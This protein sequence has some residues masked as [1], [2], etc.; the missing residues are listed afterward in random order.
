MQNLDLLKEVTILLVDDDDAFRVS[1]CNTLE[2][3]GARVLSAS[4]GHDAWS[5]FKTQEVMIVIADIRMGDFSGLSLAKKIRTYNSTIPI[6]IV[7][8]YTQ[9][10]DLIEACRLN[11]I[12][13]LVKPFSF[14]SL[15]N[16]LKR[17]LDRLNLH[18]LI[19]NTITPSIR[20]NPYTKMLVTNEGTEV[21]LSKNEVNIIEFLIAYRGQ[22]IGY[23]ALKDIIGEDVSSAALKNII[24][25]LRKKIGEDVIENIQKIGYMLR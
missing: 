6:V 15:A 7:S 13:Y 1:T 17:C 23:A 9:T 25:R 18:K 16:T 2:M 3:L 10:E 11:L 5:Y 21:G 14:Q 12:E 20:Y 22:V 4:N 19:Y 24:L 8:S